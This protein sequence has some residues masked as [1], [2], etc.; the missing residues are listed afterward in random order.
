MTTQVEQVM[1]RQEEA[2]RVGV[3]RRILGPFRK[4]M[5]GL[6]EAISFK[7]ENIFKSKEWPYY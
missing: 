2:V 1:A 7:S 5:R 6:R 3:F 4:V